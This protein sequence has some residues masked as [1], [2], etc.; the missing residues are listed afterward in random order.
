MDLFTA[1]KHDNS[2]ASKKSNKY[3]LVVHSMYTSSIISQTLKEKQE[4]ELVNVIKVQK[5]L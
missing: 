3:V 2:H 1:T 4:M 5:K